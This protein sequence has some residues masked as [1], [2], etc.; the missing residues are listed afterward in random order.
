[1]N[2][3]QCKAEYREGSVICADCRVELFGPAT[4]NVPIAVII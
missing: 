1:M 4:R 3:S 2:C